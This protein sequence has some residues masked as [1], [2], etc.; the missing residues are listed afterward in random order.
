M[1]LYEYRCKSCGSS[2]EIIQKVSE[3]PL[4]KCIKCG[5]K[6]EKVIS[7]PALQFKGN[8]WYVTDYAQKNNS[9]KEEKPTTKKSE[10]TESN[11]DKK[12]KSSSS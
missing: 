1:P 7:P 9:G 4:K 11:T 3:T 10:K 6:L 5:G 8:G 12:G 2:F